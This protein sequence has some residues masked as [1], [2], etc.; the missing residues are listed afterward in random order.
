MPVC[1]PS[2]DYTHKC[3]HYV[4]CVLFDVEMYSTNVQLCNYRPNHHDV[5]PKP[6]VYNY[7]HYPSFYTILHYSITPYHIIRNSMLVYHVKLF[8]ALRLSSNNHCCVYFFVQDHSE[9]QWLFPLPPHSSGCE[10]DHVGVWRKHT[11]RH[12]CQPRGQVLLLRLHGLWHGSVPTLF[13]K[14]MNGLAQHV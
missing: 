14:G 2:I 5:T 11:Q 6:F 1:T 10:W 9:G 4:N 8:C 12:I 3:I 13:I 7:S